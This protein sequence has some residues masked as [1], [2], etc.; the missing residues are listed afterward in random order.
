[1]RNGAQLGVASLVFLL[2]GCPGT[3]PTSPTQTPMGP[4]TGL[5]CPVIGDPVPSCPGIALTGLKLG[6]SAPPSV[7]FDSKHT[8]RIGVMLANGSTVTGTVRATPLFV[9]NEPCHGIGASSPITIT[10][11]VDYIG[12]LGPSTPLCIVHSKMTF[13][14]FDVS[15]GVFNAA[16]NPAIQAAVQDTVH[17]QLDQA[18]VSALS[19][20]APGASP[21]CANFQPLP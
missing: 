1:M 20:P 21:R 2:A 7:T 4:M 16:W 13:T 6:C 18:V 19:T 14:Q 9:I 3:S 12:D 10:F 11:G 17:R 15:G 8:N 5:G